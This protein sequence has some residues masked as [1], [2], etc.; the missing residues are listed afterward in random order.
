MTGAHKEASKLLLTA[1]EYFEGN[2][3]NQLAE[4]YETYAYECY[5]SNQI[6]EAI[7]FTEKVLN[8][9]NGLADKEK[10]GNSLCFLSRLWWF[11]GKRKNAE[12]FGRRAVEVLESHPPSS[13]KAMAF[14]NMS[15]LKMLSDEPAD[16][17]LWGEEAIEMVKE[18][19]DEEI[20][21]HAMNNMGTAQMNIP[22][23]EQKG[24]AMLQ[25]S[26]EIALKNSYHEHAARAYTNLVSCSV[27]MKNFVFAKKALDEGIRYCEERHL[28][29]L[30]AYMLSWKARM[31]LETGDWAE[32]CSIAEQLLKNENQPAIIKITA[33][34]VL[35][36]VIMR[37]GEKDALTLLLEAKTMSFEMM[38]LQRVIPSMVALLEYEWLTGEMIIKKDD[39]E[40]ASALMR[41]AGIDLEKN[42]FA[43]WMKK[44]E[45][46]LFQ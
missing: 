4:L 19:G 3:T 21:S 20:H 28:S 2:D 18:L 34:M 22:S 9:W 29:T 24:M 1:I 32:A 15:Q 11:D 16:C 41:K 46:I 42:E 33:L 44:Q 13:A 27:K 36:K 10:V 17:I 23:S 26:L 30:T 7:A 14:S 6:K 31:N 35:A 12:D 43:F 37:R 39:I 40:Q 45:G 25:Q 5:L 8:L 38:E